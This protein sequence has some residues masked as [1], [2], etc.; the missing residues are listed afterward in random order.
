MTPPLV[1]FLVG[2]HNRP[3]CLRAL[4]ATLALQTEPRWEAVL[5]DEGEGAWAVA[6]AIG[7]PRVTHLDCRPYA[8]DWHQTA[9]ARGL[10]LARGEWLG[11]PADD[12]Y[13]CP[14]YLEFML[15]G[16]LAQG[17]GL[18]YCDW[19]YDAAGYACYVSEP[20]VG[21]IDVGGFLV[22]REVLEQVGWP[23]RDHEG[24][25]RFVQACVEAGVP[26]GRVGHILYVKN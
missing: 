11:F 23:W 20:R 21:R 4:L 17:W 26:H 22:R 3:L 25:G 2:T 8:G 24:D 18:V 16:A 13:Y 1:S 6:D 19:V 5:C 12:A 9:R 7:D 14:R 10:E 15:A